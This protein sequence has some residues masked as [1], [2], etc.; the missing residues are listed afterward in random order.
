MR[1]LDFR[2]SSLFLIRFPALEVDLE[3]AGSSC[4]DAGSEG[5]SGESALPLGESRPA[6]HLWY[7]G[8]FSFNSLAP[9]PVQ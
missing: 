8:S 6:F 9:G 4:E 3:Q 5:G 2:S 7:A 1:S